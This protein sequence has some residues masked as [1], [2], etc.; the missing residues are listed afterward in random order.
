M[1][2]AASVSVPCSLPELISKTGTTPELISKIPDLLAKGLQP[3]EE[4]E[5]WIRWGRKQFPQ[6]LLNTICLLVT[7]ATYGEK[8]SWKFVEKTLAKGGSHNTMSYLL[9]HVNT[10]CQEEGWPPYGVCV[11]NSA[12]ETPSGFFG[13]GTVL[14]KAGFGMSDVPALVGRCFSDAPP[15]AVEIALSVAKYVHKNRL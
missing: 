6:R 4:R 15:S 5:L 8:T 9:R 3:E 13:E 2:R 14:S 11:V 7:N 1:S 10:L 12:G